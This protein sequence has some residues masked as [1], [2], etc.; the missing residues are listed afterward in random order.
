VSAPQQRGVRQAGDVAL[1][2][3][4]EQEQAAIARTRQKDEEDAWERLRKADEER[5]RN[6]MD[7]SW[8]WQSWFA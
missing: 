6:P 2:A 4:A 1:A 5:Q 3:E 7:P 8:G